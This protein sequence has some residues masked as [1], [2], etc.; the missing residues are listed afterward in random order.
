MRC[1][2]F[3]ASFPFP[4]IATAFG[5]TEAISSWI[6][7]FWSIYLPHPLWLYIHSKTTDNGAHTLADA[8][9]GGWL[10]YFISMWIWSDCRL[11]T[12]MQ[13]RMQT[14]CL[15]QKWHGKYRPEEKRVVVHAYVHS[16]S[17][18]IERYLRSYRFLKNQHTWWSEW[19][20]CG[21]IL[22][23]SGFS[24]TKSC[25]RCRSA[26]RVINHDGVSTDWWNNDSWILLPKGLK[27]KL[28]ECSRK[29][30][31]LPTGDSGQR[32]HWGSWGRLSHFT[33]V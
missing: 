15:A 24:R 33:F 3:N 14:T 8:R 13:K 30:T 28:A 11:E 19:G 10:S 25:E 6:I 2:W 9:N 4:G 20:K 31:I 7:L 12:Y 22:V 18:A 23:V 27:F 16:R 32:Q 26:A 29:W 1:P 5:S 21:T 17:L